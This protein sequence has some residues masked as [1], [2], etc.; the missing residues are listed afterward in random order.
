ML[1]L[2]INY[3][4]SG[5]G[6]VMQFA[7]HKNASNRS[8]SKRC[9]RGRKDFVRFIGIGEILRE[10]PPPLIFHRYVD[11]HKIR[12][13]CACQ[14]VDMQM[15]NVWKETGC[16][17]DVVTVRTLRLC[18]QQISVR[19]DLP[20]LL[21]KLQCEPYTVGTP[22]HFRGQGILHTSDTLGIPVN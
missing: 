18:V 11:G 22:C 15:S 21:L 13:P 20:V 10:L 8:P 3:K 5:I 9:I 19:A 14:S 1:H 6:A 2:K 12:I 16:R 17:C 4:E 7:E